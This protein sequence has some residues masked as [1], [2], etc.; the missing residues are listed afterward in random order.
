MN[1]G[2]KTVGPDPLDA[3]RVAV[4]RFVRVFTVGFGTKEGALIGAE[5]WCT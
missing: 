4:D 3:A 5:G 1:N 2:P